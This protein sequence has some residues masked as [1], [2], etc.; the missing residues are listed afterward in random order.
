MKRLAVVHA[1]FVTILAQTSWAGQYQKTY[2]EGEW[3]TNRGSGGYYGCFYGY[4]VDLND[5]QLQDP[6]D[7]ADGSGTVYCNYAWVPD[8][9]GDDPPKTV[10]VAQ[11]CTVTATAYSQDAYVYVNN[12]LGDQYDMTSGNGWISKSCSGTHYTLRSNPGTAFSVMCTPGMSVVCTGGHCEGGLGYEVSIAPVVVNLNGVQ[13]GDSMLEILIGQGCTGTIAVAA[14]EPFPGSITLSDFHW[15]VS[16]ETF[17][18]FDVAEGATWAHVIYLT[19][20]DLANQ[21]LHWYWR[22]D[23]NATASCTAQVF[24]DGQPIGTAY[25]A[26]DVH[27]VA[28]LYGFSHVTGQTTFQANYTEIQCGTGDLPWPGGMNFLGWVTTPDRFV[29]WTEEVG[30]CQLVQLCNIWRRRYYWGGYTPSITTTDDNFWL[31]SQWPYNGPWNANG[32]HWQ[33]EDMPSAG[34]PSLCDDITIND[35]FKMYLM[36][37]PPGDDRQWVPLHRLQWFWH[38]EDHWSSFQ[39][40]YYDPPLATITTG[41][42]ERWYYHPNWEHKWTNID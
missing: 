3:S 2:S 20:E 6:I 1:F 23:E 38:V 10:V 9:P 18:S 27:V 22:K 5:L 7:Y 28:P 14:M 37:R 13:I 34:L 31:D 15:S 11:T 8:Y 32:Q 41:G 12:G 25:A 16:G 4:G 35:A 33:T 21:T 42:D 24:V 26:R 17:R 29:D 36:Y 40:W 19:P 39:Y 30:E